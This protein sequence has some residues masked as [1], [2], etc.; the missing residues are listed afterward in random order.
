MI[1]PSAKL[2]IF[3][4]DGHIN[5]TVEHVALLSPV[6]HDTCRIWQSENISKSCAQHQK[7]LD[8][9]L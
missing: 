4:Q 2:G 7:T 1:Y 5:H 6:C 3:V 8:S 9:K